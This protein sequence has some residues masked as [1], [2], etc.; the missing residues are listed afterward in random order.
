MSTGSVVYDLVRGSPGERKEAGRIPFPIAPEEGWLTVGLLAFVLLVAAWSVQ[1]AEWV[2]N[3]P[4]LSLTILLA[5]G[6]ALALAKIRLSPLL[7]HPAGFLLGLG[8]VYWQASTVITQGSWQDKLREL[9]VRLGLF[10]QA[11]RKGDISVDILPFV[12]CL[13]LLTLWATARRQ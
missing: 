4:S 11:A 2:R 10:V 1:Q 5:A 7:L 13:L 3:L 12:F 9:F 6:A 8:W